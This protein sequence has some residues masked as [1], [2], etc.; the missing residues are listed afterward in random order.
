M[1]L[2]N[3]PAHNRGSLA[4]YD[5][6]FFILLLSCRTTFGKLSVSSLIRGR[7]A[8]TAHENRL[9]ACAGPGSPA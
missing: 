7:L 9:V 3:S 6:S 4:T 8:S 1:T 2:G 5:L